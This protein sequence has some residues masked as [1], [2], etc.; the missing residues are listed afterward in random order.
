MRLKSRFYRKLARDF[1][2]DS[3]FNS[4]IDQIGPCGVLNWFRDDEIVN[5]PTIADTT[6]DVINSRFYF[7]H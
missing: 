6:L 2:I 5:R 3:Q 1:S 4:N 7:H